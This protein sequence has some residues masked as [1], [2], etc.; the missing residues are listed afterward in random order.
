MSDPNGEKQLKLDE[1]YLRMAMIWAENSPIGEDELLTQRMAVAPPP[2]RLQSGRDVLATG[3]ASS[4]RDFA[5]AAAHWSEAMKLDPREDEY[6]LSLAAMQVKYGN[7]DAHAA[8]FE[9]LKELSAKPDKRLGSLRA[10]IDY[11]MKRGDDAQAK[12]LAK[13]LA[14]D[15]KV[16]AYRSP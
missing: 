16:P 14:S 10:M 5:T 6:R 12:E 8:A 11:A 9:V 4:I 7:S 2:G 15:P 1:R 3:V 13:T